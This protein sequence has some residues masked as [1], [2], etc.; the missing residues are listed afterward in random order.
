MRK[1]MNR[2]THATEDSLE[3]ALQGD[4]WEVLASRD[5]LWASCTSGKRKVEWDLPSFMQTGTREVAWSMSHAR[6]LGLLPHHIGCAVDFGCGPGR[7]SGA[8]ADYADSVICVDISPT[9]L[10]HAKENHPGPNFQFVRGLEEVA[11][12]SVDLVYTTFVLQHITEAGRQETFRAFHRVLRPGALAIFQ[13]PSK[14]RRTF[15]GL[16]WSTLPLSALM[17]IQR[18]LLRFPEAMPM[19]WAEPDRVGDELRQAGLELTDT[20]EGLR[21]SPNWFDAW[22]FA[23]KPRTTP[24]AVT[25]SLE[26]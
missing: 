1:D 25:H 5:P 11:D 2:S 17:W 21:Y 26:H 24:N 14:P 16:V 20:I 15:G 23:L 7:L 12:A 8:L 13:L 6:A 18:T 4:A 3:D 22:H 19:H 10:R 9:M